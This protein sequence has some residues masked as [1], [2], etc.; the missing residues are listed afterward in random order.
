M[1]KYIYDHEYNFYIYKAIII[2]GQFWG[3]LGEAGEKKNVRVNNIKIYCICVWGG[4]MKCT[5]SCLIEGIEKNRII[6]KINLIKV[7]YVH[8]EIS[9][10]KHLNN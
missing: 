8:C 3:D 5:E 4:I 2:M 1:H 7:Q 10:Q 6:G 9:N